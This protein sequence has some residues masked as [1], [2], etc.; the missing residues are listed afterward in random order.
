M[1]LGEFTIDLRDD[2]DFRSAVIDEILE[3]LLDR[4]WVRIFEA[5]IGGVHDTWIKAVTEATVHQ[6][7]HGP[8][9]DDDSDEDDDDDD[10]DMDDDDE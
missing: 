5:W 4:G 2:H 6:T 8:N 3:F 9:S 7:V 1:A 10:D